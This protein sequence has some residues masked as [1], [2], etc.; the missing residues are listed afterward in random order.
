MNDP[1]KKYIDNNREAF[2]NKEPSA[3]LW[4]KIQANIP[5][6]NK[7]IETPKRSIA[8]YWSIAASALVVVSAGLYFVLNQDSDQN[9]NVNQQEIVKKSVQLKPEVVKENPIILEKSNEEF[10]NKE[11]I[12]SSRIKESENSKQNNLIIDQPST[13][14]IKEDILLT[15]NDE[16]STS[17]RIDAI[18]KLGEYE[19]LNKSDLDALK[20]K[21]L[22][23]NNTIVRLNAIEVLAKKTPKSAVSEELT[24]IFLQQDDPMIQMELIGIIGKMDN[25]KTVPQLTK[26]L[27]EMVLDPQTMPFVKDE[28]YAILLKNNVSQ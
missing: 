25:N 1:L 2:E 10:K 12:I 6:Q 14:N 11:T 15:L 27:Q 18:A 22:H 21:A 23:D 24:N 20:Q 26:K 5:Q 13:D 9:L 17:N 7:V 19:A 28:A 8:T 4:K 16:Q 3:E